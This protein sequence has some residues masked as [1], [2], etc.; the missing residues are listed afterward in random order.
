MLRN[1][2]KLLVI[3]I[4]SGLLFTLNSLAQTPNLV[5]LNAD[6]RTMDKLKPRAEA[7]AITENK[8][9]AVGSNVNIK[10]LIG[11]NTK[12]IDAKGKL[13]IPGFNDSH[14]HFFYVGS[15][16]F[17]IDFKNAKNSAE[18]LEKIRFHLRFL[19]AGKWILG[20]FQTE[21]DSA[22][23]RFPT[24]QQIDELTLTRPVFIFLKGANIAFAN[25]YAMNLAGIDKFDAETKATGILRGSSVNLV[26]RIT[27]SPLF[28]DVSAILE[29]SSNYAAAMGVTSVQDVDS[30]NRFDTYQAL[31]KQGKLKNRIYDCIPLSDWQK[32][33]EQKIVRATGSPMIRRG[34]LK[35]FSDGDYENIP[36]LF[37]SIKSADNANLQVM[38][39][40]IGNSANDIVLTVFEKVLQENGAKD[41]R[42]RI[43]HAHNFRPNDLKRFVNSKTIASMQ[44]Y[45]FFDGSGDDSKLFRQ[46][47]QNKAFLSFG[48]DANIIDLNPMF[49]IYAA[50]FGENSSKGISVEEAVRAYT[51]DSAYAEFQENLKGSITVGKIADLIILSENIFTIPKSQIKEV[52]VLQTI[53]DGKIVYSHNSWTN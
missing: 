15:Q 39:H 35:H 5:I 50:V 42:F 37:D 2:F 14:V 41:R 38:M 24:K 9:S 52:Q 21:N 27:P 26:R 22:L 36:T 11:I 18:V 19:P 12:V 51:L 33:A 3:S 34:C 23:P 16:F 32:L 28:N 47:I 13:V 8:I 53:M 25:S 46:I 10:Q 17:S 40:A 4:L 48:S 6:I 49:G 31:E 43:E 29:A 30:D 44:P 45:L 1:S 20:G 7:V